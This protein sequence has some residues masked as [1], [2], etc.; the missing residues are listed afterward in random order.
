[1]V[2]YIVSIFF[3]SVLLFANL[4]DKIE[5][6][7]SPGEYAKQENL[8]KVL[9]RDSNSFYRVSDGNVDSLKVI[10]VLEDNG[11]FK[12]FYANPITLKVKFVTR[13]N[14]LI[15]MKVIKESLESI[16]YNYFLTTRATKKENEFVWIINLKTKHLINPI[17]FSQELKKRGCVVKDI[18]KYG[19]N[20]WVYKIN[21]D[22]ARLNAKKVDIDTSTKLKKPI[23]PYLIYANN[24][25]KIKIKTSFSDHWYPSVIFLDSALHVVS[26]TK[27]DSRT[28]VLKLD[29]P[30]NSKYI[31]IADMYTLDN[32]KHGLSIYLKSGE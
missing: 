4:Q 28:Y 10:K 32:I 18:E 17:L 9:F 7:I 2:K 31:R 19:D 23:E 30:P 29:I 11:L 8:L 3:T 1:M 24:A 25:V 26:Q 14:P 5:N 12:L 27:I 6:F 13:K 20:L 21:S 22:D 15:F 16:G